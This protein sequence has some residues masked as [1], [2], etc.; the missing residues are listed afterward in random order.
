MSVMLHWLEESFTRAKHP[1]APCSLVLFHLGRGEVGS[2]LTW[3]VNLE[4]EISL[5]SLSLF[6][7]SFPLRMLAVCNTHRFFCFSMPEALRGRLH[8]SGGRPAL[9]IHWLGGLIWLSLTFTLWKPTC[10]QIQ[11]TCYTEGA[12][13]IVPSLSVIKVILLYFVPLT[14]LSYFPK[15]SELRMEKGCHL[16]GP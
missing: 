9:S 5:T 2:D 13:T 8:P 4:G 6:H 14:L 15:G 10:L 12:N 1:N 16:L 7:L 11:A 3:Q